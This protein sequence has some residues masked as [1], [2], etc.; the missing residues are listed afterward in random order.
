METKF[1]KNRMRQVDL[2]KSRGAAGAGQIAVVRTANGDRIRIS[3]IFLSH[4]Q[5]RISVKMLKN[6]LDF[7]KPMMRIFAYTR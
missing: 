1:S 4:S 5:Q 2:S 3:Q 6:S 7:I